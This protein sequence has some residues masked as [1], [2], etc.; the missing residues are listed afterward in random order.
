M[1]IGS[2]ESTTSFSMLYRIAPQYM[3]NG[4]KV[5]KMN[6]SFE[7]HMLLFAIS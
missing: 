4:W 7:R 3:W 2:Q 5:M 6:G 1:V